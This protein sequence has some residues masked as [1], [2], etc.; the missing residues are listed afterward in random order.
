MVQNVLTGCFTP[1]EHRPTRSPGLVTTASEVGG[2]RAALEGTYLW[3][4]G[5]TDGC[6]LHPLPS[7][8]HSMS[9]ATV[10]PGGA[11]VPVATLASTAIL[12]NIGSIPTSTPASTIAPLNQHELATKLEQSFGAYLIGTYFGVL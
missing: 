5:A 9:I 4:G 10:A 6:S 12:T 7:H 11:L 3:H 8:T 2:R 1:P